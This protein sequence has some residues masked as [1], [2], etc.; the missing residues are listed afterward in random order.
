MW[1]AEYWM[2]YSTCVPC[3]SNLTLRKKSCF[4]ILPFYKDDATKVVDIFTSEIRLSWLVN[5]VA[6]DVH[7]TQRDRASATDV[8][9]GLQASMDQTLSCNSDVCGKTWNITND[10]YTIVHKDETIY[11]FSNF[12]GASVDVWDMMNNFIPHFTEHVIT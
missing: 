9:C 7:T 11:P 4:H 2:Y 5:T 3:L 8:S 10:P 1:T 6:A 12:N